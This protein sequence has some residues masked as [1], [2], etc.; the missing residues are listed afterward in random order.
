MNRPS[1][2]EHSTNA[3]GE[4]AQHQVDDRIRRIVRRDGVL[5]RRAIVRG[6]EGVSAVSPLWT[7]EALAEAAWANAVARG[8]VYEAKDSELCTR[9]RRERSGVEKRTL[10]RVRR[11]LR[12]RLSS[13]AL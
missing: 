1:S 5:V 6:H 8:L 3:G 11:T 7:D 9:A 13:Y 4:D 10:P 12:P 2:R